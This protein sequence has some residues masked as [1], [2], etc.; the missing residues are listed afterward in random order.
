VTGPNYPIIRNTR[1]LGLCTKISCLDKDL[2][3]L[4]TCLFH[5]RHQSH[6]FG[7]VSL[8]SSSSASQSKSGSRNITIFDSFLIQHHLLAMHFGAHITCPALRCFWEAF[9]FTSFGFA[10][11]VAFLFSDHLLPRRSSRLCLRHLRLCCLHY[12]FGTRALMHHLN[13]Q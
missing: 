10:R 2:V 7:P 3:R 6:L 1:G 13:C 8:I 12:F 5:V 4:C 9:L 11:C